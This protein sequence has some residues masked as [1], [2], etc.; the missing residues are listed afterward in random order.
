[1]NKLHNYLITGRIDENMGNQVG[2]GVNPLVLK[3]RDAI[4]RAMDAIYELS[5]PGGVSP[6]APLTNRILQ[7]LSQAATLAAKLQ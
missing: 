5:P 1:M 4:D 3:G 2:G 6:N 7:L